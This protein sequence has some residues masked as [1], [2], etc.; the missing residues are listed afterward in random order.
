[1][2]PLPAIAFRRARAA[3]AAAALVLA[4]A[5]AASPAAVRAH[6]AAARGQLLVGVRSPAAAARL[7]ALGARPVRGVRAVRIAAGALRTVRREARVRYVEPNYV[8]RAQQL[9]DDPMLARQWA[10]VGA[11]GADA[12]EAWDQI[13]GGPVTVAVVDSGLD[14]AHPDL[15]GNV[16]TNPGEIPGNGIDDDGDGYV[17][18]VHGWDFVNDDGDPTDDAGHGTEV[19]GLLA[20]RGDNGVGIAGIAWDVRL[21]PLKVLDASGSGTADKVAEAISF[22]VAHGARIVNASLNGPGRSQVLED[23]IAAAEQAGVLVVVAAGNDGQDLEAH[24]SYP[25]AYRESNVVAVGS[26]GP[27]GAL[28]SFSNTGSA[29][30][31]TAPGEDVLTTARGGGYASAWGT[32]MATPLVSGTLALMAAARP[33]LPGSALVAGLE[34]G[35]RRPAG[36]TGTGRLDAAGALRQVIPAGDWRTRAATGAVSLRTPARD[37]TPPARFRLAAPRGRTTLRPGRHT[38]RWRRARDNRAVV[39]YEVRL[40]GRRPA[41]VRSAAS[42]APATRLSVRLRAGHHRWQV[43]AVDAAGNRRT[44]AVARFTV[45]R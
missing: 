30:D 13:T 28:S 40:D 34:A 7:R 17:D 9:P 27:D 2:G 36:S 1:M 42:H 29:I 10:L 26:D 4:V 5:P 21:M 11:N 24:P 43:V 15:A 41:V 20:A 3:L 39:R 44:S 32:S 19:S 38:L 25:A 37:T 45:A 18:D 33:D 22:A 12:P 23:A 31:V 35:A 14:M 8:Y 16:W 6:A